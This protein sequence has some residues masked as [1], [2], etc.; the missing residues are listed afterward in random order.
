[1][2]GA[3]SGLAA[4]RAPAQ[5]HAGR[6]GI[7]H[8]VFR[9]TT[10]GGA[11]AADVLPLELTRC[12]CIGIDGELA[13]DIDCQLEQR[14]RRVLAL[15]SG[16]DLDCDLVVSARGKDSCVVE[17]DCGRPR[18]TTMRPVQCPRMSMF[19]SSIAESMRFVITSPGERSLECTLA[20]TMSSA[21]STSGV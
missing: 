5:Q 10:L 14:A 21:A 18:P 13:A 1:M 8:A 7:D 12:V 15:R 11:V 3:K 19:G 4:G 17:L 20:T 2:F 9:D 6:P 16:V